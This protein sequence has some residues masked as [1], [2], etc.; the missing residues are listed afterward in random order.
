MDD[1]GA[2]GSPRDSGTNPERRQIRESSLPSTLLPH[3]YH[4]PRHSTSQ[5]IAPLM[6]IGWPNHPTRSRSRDRGRSLPSPSHLLLQTEPMFNYDCITLSRSLD[7][8]PVNPVSV[9][10]PG[11]PLPR[12]ELQSLSPPVDVDGPPRSTV[13]RPMGRYSYLPISR[14]MSA[15]PL[16]SHRHS[17]SH[18][19]SRTPQPL[20]PPSRRAGPS[21]GIQDIFT[22]D[23]GVLPQPEM[24]IRPLGDPY[25]ELGR[26]PVF[27]QEQRRGRSELLATHASRLQRTQVQTQRH[28]AV[29]EQGPVEGLPRDPQRQVERF[30]SQPIRG[31]CSTFPLGLSVPGVWRASLRILRLS[32]FC[33]FRPVLFLISNEEQIADQQHDGPFYPCPVPFHRKTTTHIVS[34]KPEPFRRTAEDP[35]SIAPVATAASQPPATAATASEDST[36]PK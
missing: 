4:A 33:F 19:P 21:P 14:S 2:G 10:N 23:V 35:A 30:P 36:A 24:P 27:P 29:L 32:R 13:D 25:A 31:T 12:L 8:S 1:Q 7:A 5:R 3:L 6:D 16:E 26:S 34:H 28:R 15:S 9:N 17:Y 11:L 20:R 18:R 22:D